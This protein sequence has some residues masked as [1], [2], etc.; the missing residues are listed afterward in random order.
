[1][2]QDD[3]VTGQYSSSTWSDL[4][5]GFQKPEIRNHN[6]LTQNTTLRTS[7]FEEE[8]QDFFPSWAYQGNDIPKAV[9]SFDGPTTPPSQSS[10]YSGELISW[11]DL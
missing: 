8:Q 3:I 11:L 6:E 2:N 9:L 4:Q 10:D 7:S 5:S 1:M